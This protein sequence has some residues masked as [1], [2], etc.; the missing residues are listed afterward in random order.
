M[1]LTEAELAAML[2]MPAMEP[3]EGQEANFEN[4]PN[5][6]ALALGIITVTLV[7]GTLC[8]LLRAYAR[9]YLL[10]KVQIEE[11]EFTP[12]LTASLML[13][14]IV[15]ILCAYGVYV[16]QAY[17]CYALIDTPGYFVHQWNLKL[18]QLIPTS[19]VRLV[20]LIV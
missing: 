17:C 7:I 6:N 15:L 11:G 8:V 2:D 1:S 16:G 4:P 3:P 5:E 19:F 13:I 10:R 9:V 14:S 18:G 20:R 12:S